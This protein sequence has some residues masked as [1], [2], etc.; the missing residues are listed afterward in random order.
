[1]LSVIMINCA[2]AQQQ[3]LKL[4]KYGVDFGVEFPK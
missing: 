3:F 1:M 4:D 2:S